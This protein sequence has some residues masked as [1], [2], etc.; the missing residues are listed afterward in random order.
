[1]DD[2]YI[3]KV[4]ECLTFLQGILPCVPRTIIQ[5]GTGLGGFADKVEAQLEI[6][7]TDIPHFPIPTVSS[8]SGNLI[9]GHIGD[10]AVAV[11]Q[12][13]FH[14]YEGYSTK[15]VALP[16][17][18]LSLLGA[19]NLLLTNAA[20]GLNPLYQPGSIMII[21]DHLNFLGENPLRGPNVD[22]WGPRFPDLSEPY[23][24]GLI[25]I[26]LDSANR[27]GIKN[28]ITGVY[29]CIPGPSL[30][31]PAET[32]W[33]RQ[34]GADAVGMSSVPEVLVAIHGGLKILGLSVVSNINDP[35]NFQPII[36]EN[37]LETATKV[38]PKLEQLIIEI[39]A[40]I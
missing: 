24:P 34:T 12:G 23:N 6:P 33:L 8:H 2:T 14:Y 28:V 10:H 17:R 20:G 1:M 3:H 30:E 21:R 29:A 25:K 11:L 35:G 31:T 13:R 16:V 9:I 40:N 26:A 7:Y 32:R 18:V 22:L 19:E 37:I 4:K 36:L 15:E 39:L 27:C 38:K 5:L